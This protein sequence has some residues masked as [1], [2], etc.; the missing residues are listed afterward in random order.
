MENQAEALENRADVVRDMG[1]KQGE[2]VDE[3]D[4]SIIAIKTTMAAWPPRSS[5]LA[6]NSG[7]AYCA[8]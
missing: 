7:P 6:T 1:K 8:A 3:F 2:A 4:R 5:H